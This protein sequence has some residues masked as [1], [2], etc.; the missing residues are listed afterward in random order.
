MMKRR[1][2]IALLGG[3]A[4]AWPLAARA[5]QR[6]GRVRRIAWAWYWTSGRA[7]ALR[8]FPAGR[9]ARVGLDRR[10]QSNNRSLLGNGTRKHGS[11]GARTPRVRS[12]CHRNAGVHDL[13]HAVARRLPNLWCSA[14]AAI[15]SKENSCKAGPTP[16]VTLLE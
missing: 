6:A 13:R 14:L 15:R 4:A 11:G 16:A 9:I 12:R 8:G 2:F 1:E 3:A 10:Q 7:L 5:Q